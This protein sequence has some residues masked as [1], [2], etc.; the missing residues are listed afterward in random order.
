MELLNDGL[1]D[2]QIVYICD[3][4]YNDIFNKP[5]R[6]VEP[7]RVIVVSNEELP[8]NKRIYYSRTHFKPIN[9]SGKVMSKIIAPFDNTGYRNF[10]GVCV[11]IFDSMEECIEKYNKQCEYILEEI[12]NGKKEAILRFDNMKEKVNN[13]I[14]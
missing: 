11:N 13:R 9:K 1:K 12:E 2:G 10:T 14:K 4:R 3:Y 5:I 8:K 6:H 7:T